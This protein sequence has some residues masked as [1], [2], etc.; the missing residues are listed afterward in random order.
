MGRHGAASG[1]A[2]SLPQRFRVLLPRGGTLPAASWAR[3]HRG[4]VILLWAHAFFIPAYAL[5]MGYPAGHA[6]AEGL[7]VPTTAVVASMTLLSRRIRTVVASLGL[8]SS[9][10]LLVHLSGGLIE[11]HFHFFVMVVVVSLY[12]DWLPFLAAVGYV[13]I[14]HGLF[15]AL[16]P[17][18]VFN[19]PAAINH[20]WTWAGVHALFITGISLAS[21]V[22][23]RLNEAHLEQRQ[24]AEARLREETRIVERLKWAGCW[25]PI[26]TSTMSCSGSPTSPPS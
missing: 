5:A 20:P 19:H 7:I 17:E 22:N 8:L 23:W 6:L 18:S 9:S 3:R 12:Q 25:L 26:W 1:G 13:F 11:M 15:G 24:L 16:A 2:G 21:L 14:H 10:A 4:V